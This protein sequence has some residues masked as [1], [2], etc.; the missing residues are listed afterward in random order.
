MIRIT[1]PLQRLFYHQNQI[2]LPY[3]LDVIVSDSTEIDDTDRASREITRIF[4]SYIESI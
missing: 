3:L 2:L 1:H 4:D